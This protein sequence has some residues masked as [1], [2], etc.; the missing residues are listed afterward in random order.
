MTLRGG[1]A[2]EAETTRGA[3]CDV[4]DN[5][6]SDYWAQDELVA[7]AHDGVA[8]RVVVIPEA[9]GAASALRWLRRHDVTALGAAAEPYLHAKVLV[10]ATAR[11]RE[12][13]RDPGLAKRA[14][15][16]LLDL[17]VAAPP[18]VRCL[19]RSMAWI[20][21]SARI[22]STTL[23]ELAIPRLCAESVK[24]AELDWQGNLLSGTSEAAA[25]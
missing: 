9:N 22:R 5:Y 16:S 6:L 24:L 12:A 14:E 13:V 10:C 8:L 4:V 3:T 23:A 7:A 2:R 18:A 1:A 15:E 20:A 19:L 17:M 25:A 11:M 21:R